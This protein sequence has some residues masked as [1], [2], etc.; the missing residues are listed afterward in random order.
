MPLLWSELRELV[1]RSSGLLTRPPNSPVKRL[2]G[3]C[4]IMLPQRPAENQRPTGGRAPSRRSFDT[5]AI[6]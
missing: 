1:R 4:R 2:G 5:A 6:T 3:G